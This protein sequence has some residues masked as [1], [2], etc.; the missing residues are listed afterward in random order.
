MIRRSAQSF[1]ITALDQNCATPCRARAIDITPTIADHIT[2]LWIN[3]QLGGC[4]KNHARPWL[5]TIAPLA[6]PLAGVIANLDPIEQWKR[7]LEFQVHRF[8]KFA[9]PRAPAYIGLVCD[10]DQQ[11]VR[12]FK[13]RTSLR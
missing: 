12:R 7:R 5:A 9:S 8:D 6:V 13:Q 1:V 4:A 11:E 3:V 2:P 10:D